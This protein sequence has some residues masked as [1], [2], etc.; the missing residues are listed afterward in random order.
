[1]RRRLDGIARRCL[2]AEERGATEVV[3]R[4]EIS[5]RPD[6]VLGSELWD[7]AIDCVGGTTLKEI[8]RSLRYGA[9]VA[10]SGL[11]A[12][13]ELETTVYPFITRANALIG[14]DAVEATTAT[15]DRVWAT[16]GEVAPS[17]DFAG[18]VDRVVPLENVLEGLDTIRRGATRGRILVS[19]S[20]DAP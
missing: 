15:R 17:V 16:L 18:L 6:R 9:A 4:D 13:P 11:V 20:V 5:D 3:G 2:L 1:M 7:G 10:A 12:S 19:I 14:I 8:L